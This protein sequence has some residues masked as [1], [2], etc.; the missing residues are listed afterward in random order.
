LDL[1]LG[2][3]LFTSALAKVGIHK[4]WPEMR[5]AIRTNFLAGTWEPL[6]RTLL[7]ALAIELV[8]SR[9]ALHRCERPECRRWFVKKFSRAMYC[10]TWCSEIMRRQG[11]SQW[12]Q[13]HSEEISK[14]RRA[15]T[16]KEKRSKG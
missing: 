8:R 11:Q 15:K 6:P 14:K 4:L 2:T 13:D 9:K 3:G 10:S 16:A 5:P 1:V 12:A 7:D